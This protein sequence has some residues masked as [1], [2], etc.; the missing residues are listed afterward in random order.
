MS[1]RYDP[2]YVTRSFLPPLEDF[3][4]MLGEIWESR[5]LTNGGSHHQALEAA[6]C[7]YLGVPFISLT[8]N[9]TIALQL[10]LSA[11]DINRGEVITTPYSFP[12]TS[13]VISL[14]GAMPVF[15]DI[16][17][18]LFNLDPSGLEAAITERTR[19]IMP[20]HCYGLPCE[21]EAIAEIAARHDLPVLYDAAHA[22]AVKEAGGSVLNHGR[23][24][25]LS[26]HATK[27]FNTFEGGAVVCQSAEDK[28]RIDRLKNFGIANEVEVELAGINGKMSELNA[29]I[30]LLQL[31]YIDDALAARAVVD[32]RYRKGLAD[33][34]GI[35]VPEPSQAA[36]HNCSYFPILIDEARFGESRDAL[37][38]RLKSA[39]VF[40]RRY[41]YPLLSNLP[42]YAD[43][44]SAAL[45]SL[46]RANVVAEQVLCLPIHPELSEADQGRVISAIKGERSWVS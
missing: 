3:T 4:N 15:V 19:A 38:E 32:A 46:P 39:G 9:G 25:A 14:A 23:F 40:A 20:V 8:S 29:A 35:V 43:L 22:F 6:L 34:E 18:A 44:P 24:A 16:G 33:I 41:F 17:H 28:Q 5:I 10:A 12:A 45:T 13:H 2:I 26:F 30:G 42:M 7:D 31:R 11:L 36:R 27:V 37:Y 1:E 21:G